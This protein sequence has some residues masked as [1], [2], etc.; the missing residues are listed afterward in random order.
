MP[1]WL[2]V[3]CGGVQLPKNQHFSLKNV[4][5]HILFFNSGFT[6]FAYM[7]IE[8]AA[9][10][11]FSGYISSMIKNNTKNNKKGFTFHGYL[12]ELGKLRST[13]CVW[14]CGCVYLH[15]NGWNIFATQKNRSPPGWLPSLLFADEKIT[16]A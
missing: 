2:C 11:Y 1:G 14:V 7:K 10:G 6:L 9:N 13:V 8:S 16:P 12:D 4:K 5:P 3:A 15:I